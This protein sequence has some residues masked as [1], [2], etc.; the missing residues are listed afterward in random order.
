[1]FNTI[2]YQSLLAQIDLAIKAHNIDYA[3][4]MVQAL[5]MPFVGQQA[6]PMLE[7]MDGIK[8]D[9]TGMSRASMGLNADALQSSTKAAVSA[10]IS[11][12]QSRLELTTR[13]LAEGM[14]KLFK[15][16]LQLTV[17]NQDKARMI[18]LR[19]KWVQ[20]DPRMWDATMDVS[21][22]VGLGNGD[23]EQKMSMLGMIASKQEQA[24]QLMGPNNPL[25][26]PAQ[27]AN[28]LRKMVELSGFK[29]SS[30][31]FNAIPADYQPPAPEQKQSPEEMLAMVQV[32]SIEADIQKKAA[33][34]Q[35][36][37]EDMIRKDDRER[38]KLEIDKYV[39]IRELE[40]KYGVQ[41][42]E[43]ALNAEIERD[44]NAQMQMQPGM[45]PQ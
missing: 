38:D 41:L 28:T 45:P 20:V 17:A 42:N 44:R 34:L 13:I 27:Y 10:T 32:K 5:S 39:K 30:Q 7:Y 22:N 3:Q 8:E 29:D 31:F 19:N 4:G 40:L 14:K 24:L 15:Q 1:M 6:F 36:Q 12:S 9:R 11:A 33:D 18:R 16:I 43:I 26:T 25:V 21:I 37:R 23:I 2:A 35:L